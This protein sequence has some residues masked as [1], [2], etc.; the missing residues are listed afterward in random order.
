MLKYKCLIALSSTKKE[1]EM[2]YKQWEEEREK[3]AAPFFKGYAPAFFPRC[4]SAGDRA[5]FGLDPHGDDD[6]LEAVRPG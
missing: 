3:Q 4:L 5:A 6:A 2:E 1:K